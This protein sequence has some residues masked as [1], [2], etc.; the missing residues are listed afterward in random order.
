MDSAD[1]DLFC[2]LHVRS[3]HHLL[4]TLQNCNNVRDCG[5]PMRF[6]TCGIITSNSP[7]LNPTDSRNFGNESTRQQLRM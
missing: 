4:P 7:D 2:K 1:C 5:H 6:Q 3:V